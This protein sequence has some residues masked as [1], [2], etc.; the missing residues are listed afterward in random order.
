MTVEASIVPQSYSAQIA[1]ESSHDMSSLKFHIVWEAVHGEEQ[2][3]DRG[4]TWKEGDVVPQRRKVMYQQLDN[5]WSFIAAH[6]FVNG[7]EGSFYRPTVTYI[8]N[9]D[10]VMAWDDG[11]STYKAVYD[12]STWT[13][14]EVYCSAVSPQVMTHG[15]NGLLSSTTLVTLSLGGPPYRVQFGGGT[16]NPPIEEDYGREVVATSTPDAPGD[17]PLRD[18]TSYFSV[19]L[20]SA[21]LKLT[22]G[23]VVP[24]NFIPAPDT[25]RLHEA[26]AWQY[27]TTLPL[28]LPSGIDSVLLDGAIAL[29]SP[30]RLLG[31][32]ERLL[33]VLFDVIDAQ[34]GQLIRKIG[35][36]RA[37]GRDTT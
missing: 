14:T 9:D 10:V 23:S 20:S 36:E 21:T 22:N 31:T 16:C 37:F 3:T 27:L 11:S 6:E 2:A 28:T 4:E 19:R 1:G 13:I 30:G 26:N 8:S 25:A 17:T 35:S 24:L 29:S 33:R 32:G 12:G 18:S 7:T 34:S 15:T 5:N